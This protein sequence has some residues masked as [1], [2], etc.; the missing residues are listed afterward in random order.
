MVRSREEKKDIEVSGYQTPDY[1]EQ[2]Y[3][4]L[5]FVVNNDGFPVSHAFAT[6]AEALAW[7]GNSI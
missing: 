2:D 1:V 4:G 5:W 3:N 7:I 6:E